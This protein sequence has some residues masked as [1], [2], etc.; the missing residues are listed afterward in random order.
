MKKILL[1]CIM[2]M[3]MLASA[4][5]NVEMT[6]NPNTS[7]EPKP[8]ADESVIPKNTTE[9]CDDVFTTLD[10]ETE[11]SFYGTWKVEK[12]LG[13]A[14]SYNDASEYP[15]GQK[16][17]GDEFIIKKDFFSSKGLKNYN[18]YQHE[19]KNPLYRLNFICYN[20]GSFYRLFKTDPDA[21]NINI[22]DKVKYIV[23]NDSSTKLGIPLS[24]F[25]VN[26]DRLI[27]LLEATNFELKK[28]TD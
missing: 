24:F 10:S 14:N 4:C 8:E 12:L 3:S 9:Y 23:I 19:L 15:T 6:S 18:D 21:L 20:T 26:N 1:V 5:G 11:K 17:I 22:N 27:L 2:I 7:S 28:I 16:I 13:F 25:I